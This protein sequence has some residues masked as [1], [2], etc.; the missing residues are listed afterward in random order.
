MTKL[1][2]LFDEFAQEFIFKRFTFQ[3]VIVEKLVK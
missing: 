3:E 1:K 2:P